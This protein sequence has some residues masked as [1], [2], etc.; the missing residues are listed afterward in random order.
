MALPIKATPR[1]EGKEAEKF[2]NDIKDNEISDKEYERMM[3]NYNALVKGCKCLN[4]E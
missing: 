2:L 4:S 3:R 1:L